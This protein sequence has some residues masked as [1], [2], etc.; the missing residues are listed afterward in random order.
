MKLS[1]LKGAFREAAEEQIDRKPKPVIRA[2]KR[3]P[4]KWELAFAIEKLEPMKMAQ[5]IVDYHFEGMSLKIGHGARYTPDYYVVDKDGQLVFY[6]VKGRRTEAGIQ[7]LKSAAYIHKH[8]RFI[9]AY[10]G[11]GCWEYQEVG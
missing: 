10:G 9:M 11:S 4:N 3:V 6:E 8:F 1:D 5:E 7:R 2:K